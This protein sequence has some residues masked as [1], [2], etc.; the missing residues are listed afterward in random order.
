MD[1]SNMMRD[2][3]LSN[4][5][6][7]S[8]P[9]T[10][11]PKDKTIDIKKQLEVEWS[12][13]SSGKIDIEPVT[14]EDEM[15]VQMPRDEG[16]SVVASVNTLLHQGFTI[17]EAVSQLKYRF[18][19]EA[20]VEAK[21][22]LKELAKA[23]GIVGCVAIDLRG[24]KNPDNIIR[25]AKQSPFAPFIGFVIATEEQIE[26]DPKIGFRTVTKGA[27]GGS[28][29]GF[30][31]DGEEE[32]QRCP[33]HRDLNMPVVQ[34]FDAIEESIDEGWVNDR[35]IDLASFEM[36][37]E[38]ELEEVKASDKCSWTILRKAFVKAMEKRHAPPKGSE[39]A[40][41]KSQD[42]V[43]DTGNGEIEVDEKKL[44]APVE[45]EAHGINVDLNK[46]IPEKAAQ[47]LEVTD[48]NIHADVNVEEAKAALS[49][50][51]L[52]ENQE[53]EFGTMGESLG[54]IEVD[55]YSNADFSGADV[56]ELEEEAEQPEVL[57]MDDL[58]AATD[59]DLHEAAA[60]IDVEIEQF[61]DPEFK[62]TDE[63]TLDEKRVSKDD[64]IEITGELN[65]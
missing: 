47:D 32:C 58:K 24:Q 17:E 34:S 61:Q 35:L 62:G 51:G 8:D 27:S 6:W 39:D 18:V 64:D 54:D 10:F 52:S 48:S 23:E 21:E 41:D 16:T 57:E 29:D 63:I 19:P 45:V 50:E 60:T 9:K 1:L 15:V 31:D 44:V 3:S 28:I 55:Q 22:Q 46:P 26:K 53:M 5:T 65:F 25:A 56:F 4:L 13:S 33:Y 37:D 12:G 20:M 49:L 14:I 43:M 38:Q 2:A 30:M 11:E 36:L 42:Y 7:L 59:V 40:P